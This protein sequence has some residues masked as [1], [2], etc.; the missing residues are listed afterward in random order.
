MLP[1]LQGLA[2]AAEDLRI[3]LSEQRKLIDNIEN[4][5]SE[6]K[7][8]VS[9]SLNTLLG[10][11]NIL[12]RLFIRLSLLSGDTNLMKMSTAALNHVE[13]SYENAT[14]LLGDLRLVIAAMKRRNI[15]TRN[16]AI[17]LDLGLRRKKEKDED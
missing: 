4:L 6:S 17:D 15:H 12:F 5:T 2:N 9:T 7:N 16:D 13:N 14:K 11:R 1:R 10:G 8:L 3:F